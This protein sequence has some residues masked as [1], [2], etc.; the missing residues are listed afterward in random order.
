VEGWLLRPLF[1]GLLYFE[2]IGWKGSDWEVL[3]YR[4]TRRKAKLD[5]GSEDMRKCVIDS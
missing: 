1:W 4:S 3:F 5:V 2:G